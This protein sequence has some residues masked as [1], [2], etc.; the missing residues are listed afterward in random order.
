LKKRWRPGLD[1]AAAVAV[2]V[3]ALY[4]AADDDSATGGPD[5]Q[6]RIYPVVATVTD[7]GYRRVDDEELAAAVGA[8]QGATHPRA[9]GQDGGAAR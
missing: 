6:R 1:A 5:Q 9:A 7:E 4:D 8:V 3:E 2:A